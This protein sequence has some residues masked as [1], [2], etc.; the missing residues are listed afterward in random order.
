[1]T[2]QPSPSLPATGRLLALD[3]GD[4]R[5]GAAVCDD[6]Q[7]LA[8]PLLVL[9]RRSNAEDWTR[10]AK[11][12]AE[13]RVVGLLVGHPLNADGSAGPQALQ[14]A[15]YAARVAAALALPWLLWDEYGSSQ[16]AARRLAHTSR[17]RRQA[18]L[19]AAAAAVILQDYLDS[20]AHL[21]T[22]VIAPPYEQVF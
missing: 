22:V 14:T 1:M 7:L 19:D 6:R 3:V 15:R 21:P 8:S 16:E 9:E 4:K 18:P 12:A 13:Q 5:I 11:M 2:S 20:Q 17:R 10:L